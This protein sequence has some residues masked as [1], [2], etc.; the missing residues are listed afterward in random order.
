MLPFLSPYQN[1]PHTAS[2]SG[3]GGVSGSVSC[4]Q[5]SFSGP[6]SWA[7]LTAWSVSRIFCSHGGTSLFLFGGDLKKV[8][9]HRI[10]PTLILLMM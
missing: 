9:I 10:L 7:L 3:R 8:N 2:S 6:H 5:L 1:A 4:W